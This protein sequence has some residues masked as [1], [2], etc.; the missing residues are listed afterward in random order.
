M[1][2]TCSN[3]REKCSVYFGTSPYGV[4]RE[5]TFYLL[6]LIKKRAFNVIRKC[7]PTFRTCFVPR[8]NKVRLAH[9]YA[10]NLMFFGDFSQT[11]ET[12]IF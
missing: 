11:D 10:S 1:F 9:L 7:S 2:R 12:V 8:S 6:E 5:I 4:R 3:F